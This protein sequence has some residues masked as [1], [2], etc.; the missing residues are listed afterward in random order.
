MTKSI[1][2]KSSILSDVAYFPSRTLILKNG[3]QLVIFYAG[4]YIYPEDIQSSL[5]ILK[6]S[7]HQYN[8]PSFENRLDRVSN[9]AGLPDY[10]EDPFA[11]ASITVDSYI[12]ESMHEKM[13]EIERTI[14]ESVHQHDPVALHLLQS[15]PGIGKV[16]AL[17]FLYKIGDINRFPSVGTFIS[18]ARLVKCAHESAGK[19]TVGKNTK[20][21]NVHL[22]WAFGEAAC[23][24]LRDN[25]PGKNWHQKLGE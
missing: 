17:V 15:I 10:F 3:G 7:R 11:K 5:L 25:E 2:K 16:L 24:F 14:S 12:M 1:P 22:K 18:Y 13:L 19:R 8:I 9:R 4:D 23:L 20:I 6:N 21:G